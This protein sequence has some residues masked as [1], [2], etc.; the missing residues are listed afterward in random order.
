MASHE[1]TGLYATGLFEGLN[2]AVI[3]AKHATV[4]PKD[5]QLIHHI[6]KE[7]TYSE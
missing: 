2:L 6:R 4:M 3:H 7:Y 1:A 5:I